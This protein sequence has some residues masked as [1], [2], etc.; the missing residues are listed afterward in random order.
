MAIA[1]ALLSSLSLSVDA[2]TL[3]QL[4]TRSNYGVTTT[5][6]IEWAFVVADAATPESLSHWPAESEALLPDRDK[7]R[8]KT[9]LAELEKRSVGYSEQLKKAKQPPLEREEL[10]AASLYTGPVCPSY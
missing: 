3:S 7:C 5:S 8:R 9:P 1:A 4:L 6:K 10:V 2:H